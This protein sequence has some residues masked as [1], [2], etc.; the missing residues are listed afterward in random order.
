MALFGL[1]VKACGGQAGRSG[2]DTS[3]IV[4]YQPPSGAHFGVACTISFGL[5]GSLH[6]CQMAS[7]TR[8]Y[9]ELA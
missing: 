5:L 6:D 2:H 8:G 1:G 3:Q 7:L 4:Y 9:T